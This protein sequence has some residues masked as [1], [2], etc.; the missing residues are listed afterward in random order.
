MDDQSENHTNTVPASQPAA[1]GRAGA[2]PQR[3]QDPGG[4]VLR[5]EVE[6]WVN[7]GG[8]GDEPEP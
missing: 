3:M 6:V 1:V 4:A 2:A 7:E 8:D 5:N